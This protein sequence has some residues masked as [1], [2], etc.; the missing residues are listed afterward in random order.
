MSLVM[1]CYTD[2]LL[3][4]ELVN[5]LKSK[6]VLHTRFCG[7]LVYWLKNPRAKALMHFSK[8]L[9]HQFTADITTHALVGITIEVGFVCHYNLRNWICALEGCFYTFF[10]YLF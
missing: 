10:E 9:A 6:L 1:L 8:V 7:R 3:F 4:S 2:K 5:A